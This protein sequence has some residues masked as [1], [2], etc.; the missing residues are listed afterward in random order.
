M[1]SGVRRN[2]TGEKPSASNRVAQNKNES[3]FIFMIF[4]LHNNYTLPR[5][6]RV[7]VTSVFF[8]FFERE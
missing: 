7:A 6:K 1:I 2:C 5:R 3:E 4:L 8:C